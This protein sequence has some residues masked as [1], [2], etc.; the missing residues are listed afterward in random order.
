VDR[1]HLSDLRENFDTNLLLI[2]HSLGIVA[3]ARN[4]VAVVYAGKMVEGGQARGF[5]AELR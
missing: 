5:F 4:R 1:L 3:E 2:T